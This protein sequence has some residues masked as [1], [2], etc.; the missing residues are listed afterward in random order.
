MDLTD[1]QNYTI[2][3]DTSYLNEGVSSWCNGKRWTVEL[4]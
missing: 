1:L 4:E 2:I 3:M